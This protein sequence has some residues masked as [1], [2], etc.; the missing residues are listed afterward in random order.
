MKKPIIL[1]TAAI[2]AVAGYFCTQPHQLG[3]EE[4]EEREEYRENGEEEE[5]NEA[6]IDKQLGMWFY[7]RAYPEPNNLDAKYAAAWQQYL[8]IRNDNEQVYNRVESFSNWASLGPSVD[9]SG[10]VI[11]GRVLCVAI[12]KT[13]PNNLWAGSASGGIWKSTNAGSSW[14]SVN[15]GFHV[16]GVSAML[17][18]PTN[19]NIIYAG[20]GE[21]CRVDTSNIGFNVW[22]T[23]GTYG[24]GILRSTDGGTTWSQILMKNT[25]QMFAI[26]ALEFDP[27]TP[28]TVYACATDGLYR[29][30]NASGVSPVW[31]QILNKI[32]VKDVAINPTNTNQIVATVGNMVN[33]DK[34][35]YRTTNGNN[36]SPTWAK[37]TTGLPAAFEG[38]INL[39]NAGA[40]EL[41]ASIGISSSTA[42]TNREIYR[43]TDF[44]ATWAVVGGT[45]ATT[46][47]N[48]CSYQFWV[49]HTVAINPFATDSIF[50]GGVSLYRYRVSTQAKATMGTVHADIHDI[51]YDPVNRGRIYVCCDGGIYKSTNGG[52]TFSVINT[53][54]NATQ[55]YASLGVSKNTATPK[56]MIGGLQDNGQVLFNGTQWN[57]VS[58]GGGDG[59]S[60]AIHPTKDD[61]MLASRDAKQVFRSANGGAGGTTSTN[62]WGFTADS[63]TAF[64]APIAFAPS[65]GDSVYLGSDNIHIS[66]NG[67]S[68]F[69]NDPVAGSAGTATAYIDAK[70]KT[71]ITIAVS[72]YNSQKVYVSTSNFAQSDNDVNGIIVTGTP[73]LL[74]TTT[75]NRPF[76]SIMGIVGS[77]L[78][79][80]F[81]NDIAI[82]PT[83]DDSVFVALGGF[84]TAHIY[85]TG[86]GGSH[87][88]PLGG[89]GSSGR[90]NAVL[91]DVPFNA[92][93]FDPNNSN[94][95]YAGC[96]FGV[97]VSA[98][99]GNSWVDFNTG[100]PIAAMLVMDLQISSDK[101][102]IAAT[103]GRGVYR[104]DLFTGTTLPA[105]LIDFGG[106]NRTTTNDLHWTV[107]QESGIAKYELERSADARNYNVIKSVT[108]RNSQVQTNYQFSDLVNPAQSEYYYRLKII[109][110]D[111]TYSY[112]VVVFIRIPGKTNFSVT[113]NLVHDYVLLNY[114]LSNNQQMV[115]RLFNSSGALLRKNEYAGQAGSGVYT[116]Y[117][118][119][120]YPPGVYLMTVESGAVKKTF[121]LVRN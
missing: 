90:I 97:Y 109:E 57:Q 105:T 46:T 120:N 47:T 78:P 91:P 61:T 71:A 9:G 1:L 84:G 32:Y 62:Y 2:I 59:T 40:T 114:N 83:N 48:H 89:I 45:T 23:R 3:K 80:R 81:V 21:V 70:N 101:K 103:H 54:L 118:L 115:I 29:S 22:K 53:G 49:A 117:G 63:R 98:D 77:Q 25:N 52:S 17:V 56:R 86:D 26:Q 37:I 7:S 10:N 102:L 8:Q 65:K 19:S 72:P 38:Y 58:W 14:T 16:L 39:D 20:T 36:A 13:N 51:K 82:S 6:G 68:S 55:F 50:F 31:S 64:V 30:T 119:Q 11:A 88:A 74:R 12:D 43:S 44:G 24:V 93:V 96:D 73:N 60:C 108:L 42:A 5:E 79:N 95:I 104:T 112:S 121:K 110:D 87:W 66:T 69:T 85:V 18:D 106:V 116:I 41:F 100:F 28:N 76:S 99:R 113:G 4:N 111:G 107:S 34:G 35:V 15:T 33:A 67:G 94:I 75:G 92:L 27:T